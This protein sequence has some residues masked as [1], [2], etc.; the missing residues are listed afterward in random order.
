MVVK[1]YPKEP[2]EGW[3]ESPH[4]LLLFLRQWIDSYFVYRKPALLAV[5]V[6]HC[7]LQLQTA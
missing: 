3:E 1:V 6:R 5:L 7:R 4:P 2:F